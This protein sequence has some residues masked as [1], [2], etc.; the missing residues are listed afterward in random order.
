MEKRLNYTDPIITTYTHH[1]HL[2][3]IL[4]ANPETKGWI[5]SNYIQVFI[6][7][8]L[9][10]NEWGD[11][12]F[13]MTYEIR[14]TELCKWIDV[15]KMSRLYIDSVEKD[16][17]K[18]LISMLDLEFF[19][20]MMVNYRFIRGS[21]D[22]LKEGERSHD[23]MIWGYDDEKEVFLCA[24][25]QYYESG[26]YD[27]FECSFEDIRRS[28]ESRAEGLRN[29]LLMDTVYAYRLKEE[30]DYEYSIENIIYWLKAFLNGDCP[31][32][33]VGYN[34][35]NKKEI[36]WGMDYYKA[37][38][39]YI[40]I[41]KEYIPVRLTYLL[42]DHKK[43]MIERLKYIEESGFEVRDY[44]EAYEMLCKKNKIA[45]SLALKYNIQSD[46]RTKERCINTLLGIEESE[47]ETL[48][49][50]LESLNKQLN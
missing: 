31:E 39:D 48:G 7:K 28:Y 46:E 38:T 43:L 24:D 1:A 34:N 30:C 14:N 26:K 45:I 19:I 23:L 41:R 15:Q 29:S 27:T 22:Y 6:N 50:L 20:H 3:S 16:I 35:C 2:L 8:D 21:K 12:Y 44:I 9:I 5:F 32:Y 36:V 17:C 47:R 33:W 40:R 11:F 18:F 10:K 25:F 13:P 37:L 49:Q 4:G 42:L